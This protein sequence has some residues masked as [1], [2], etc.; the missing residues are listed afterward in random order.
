MTTYIPVHD[1]QGIRALADVPV[2]SVRDVTLQGTPGYD[3]PK[4]GLSA[5]VAASIETDFGRTVRLDAG[6]VQIALTERPPLPIHPKFWRSLGLNPRRANALVQK[7]FFHYRIFYAATSF[8][9]VA[10]VS[11]GATS[12]E[13]VKTRDYGRPMH[14]QVEIKDWRT[15]LNSK[16]AAA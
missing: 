8:R 10:I 14:P 13:A 1:P 16:A 2:G 12:L 11:A 9:H 15:P 6:R 3:Q 7:N 4:F 5:T